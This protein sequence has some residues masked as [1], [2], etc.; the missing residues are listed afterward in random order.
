M[1]SAWP[2]LASDAVHFVAQRTL[3]NVDIIIKYSPACTVGGLAME[4]ILHIC[5]SFL[6]RLPLMFK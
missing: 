5:F 2:D 3:E 1:C 4:S 6:H